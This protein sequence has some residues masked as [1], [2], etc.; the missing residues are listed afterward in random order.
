[1]LF[2][3]SN[4]DSTFNPSEQHPSTQAVQSR[5]FTTLDDFTE[6]PFTIQRMCELLSN[7]TR[8][9]TS[10]NKYLRAFERCVLVTASIDEYPLINSQ[11]SDTT[12]LP[13]GSSPNGN[14]VSLETMTRPELVPIPFAQRALD[15]AAHNERQRSRSRSRSPGVESR[16]KSEAEGGGEVGVELPMTGPNGTL[17]EV[18]DMTI[19]TDDDVVQGKELKK[20][21]MELD[22]KESDTK[23]TTSP[24]SQIDSIADQPS[25]SAS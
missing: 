25:E 2:S 23:V 20:A 4:D 5:I 13:I 19:D 18:N 14:P 10:S 8:H 21:R 11:E 3:G 24:P 6:A 9:Y 16:R 1:M 15:E 17:N 12:T 7:P 22:V